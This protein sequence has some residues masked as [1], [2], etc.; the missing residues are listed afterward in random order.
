MLERPSESTDDHL[1]IFTSKVTV[2]SSRY[3]QAA[4]NGGAN[5]RKG[6]AKAAKTDFQ[7]H[8]FEAFVALP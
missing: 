7:S 4:S 1:A 5:S 8:I 2:L 6:R 3:S